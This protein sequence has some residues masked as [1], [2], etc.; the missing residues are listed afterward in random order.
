MARTLSQDPNV[1]NLAVTLFAIVAVLQIADGLQSTALG[2]LRGMSDMN[3]P[4]GIT[5]VAYWPLALPISFGL[6]FWFDYGAIGIWS[7]YTLGLL[8]A[9][10]AL[11]L[12]FWHLTRQL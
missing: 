1:I 6:G 7:G 10:T 9:A 2:A 11:P 3:V 8:V 5:L 12:R 4:T